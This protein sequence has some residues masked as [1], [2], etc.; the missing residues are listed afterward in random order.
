MRRRRGS[1]REHDPHQTERGIM[2][3]VAIISYNRIEGVKNTIKHIQDN[4]TQPFE[5]I[6][7]DDGS[8]DGTTSTLRELGYTVVSGKIWA[9][10]GIKTEICFT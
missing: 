5:L 1:A 8:P 4:T 2:L 9:S 10:A 7:A 6:V 3:G